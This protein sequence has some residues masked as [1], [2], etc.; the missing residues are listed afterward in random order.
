MQEIADVETPGYIYGHNEASTFLATNKE[1]SNIT[2]HIDVREHFIREC[3]DEVRT[4]LKK[5]KSEK[6]SLDIMTKIY[7]WK[8]SNKGEK[9]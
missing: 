5:V 9:F 2:N 1:V 6:N 3:F 7:Q 8:L 4:E